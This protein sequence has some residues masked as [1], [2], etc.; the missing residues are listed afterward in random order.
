MSI[1]CAY[2]SGNYSTFLS[3]NN[4]TCSASKINRHSEDL[5]G[6]RCAT[7][8]RMRTVT[9]PNALNKRKTRAA[10]IDTPAPARRIATHQ[11]LITLMQRSTGT[12]LT[13][14]FTVPVRSD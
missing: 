12:T 10:L 11:C 8:A 14:I 3:N 13:Y 7:H 2:V 9:K 6:K 1:V 4:S 5:E